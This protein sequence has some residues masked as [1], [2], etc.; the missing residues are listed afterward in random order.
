MT[1]EDVLFRFDIHLRT[2]T[3][4][5]SPLEMKKRLSGSKV[6]DRDFLFNSK[7]LEHLSRHTDVL[8]FSLEDQTSIRSKLFRDIDFLTSNDFT[9]FSIQLIVCRDSS[10]LFGI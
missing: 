8:N 2:D 1:T 9:N 6:Y 4:S 7:D 5:P 3:T 10:C